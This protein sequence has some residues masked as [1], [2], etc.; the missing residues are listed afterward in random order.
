MCSLIASGSVPV[1]LQGPLAG[2][3]LLSGISTGDHCRAQKGTLPRDFPI[4]E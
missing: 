2:I 3:M 1:N 4:K